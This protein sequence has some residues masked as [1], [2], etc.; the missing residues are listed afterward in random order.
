MGARGP[1]PTPNKVLR[2]RGSWRADLNPGEPKP[3]AGKPTCPAWLD[4]EAKA[5][6]R[7]LVPMLHIT[8]LLTQI[9]RNALAR[10]CQLFARWKKCELFIQKYGN[11]YPLKDDKGAIKCFMQFPEVSIANSLAKQLTRLEQEFGLTPSSRSRISVEVKAN[12]ADAQQDALR[13]KFF[14]PV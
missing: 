13:R 7:Q 4:D 6:W 11:T 9:D 12:A 10:Y 1:R 3:P 14:G 8:G 5:A 2:L